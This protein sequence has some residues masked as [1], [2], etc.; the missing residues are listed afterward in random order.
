MTRFLGIGLAVLATG[1]LGACATVTRGANT[2]WEVKTTPPEAQVSTS[3]GFHCDF[4]PCSLRMPRKSRFTARV[5]KPGYKT[6]NIIV[7][8]KLAGAGG[9][10]FVGNALIGGVIG[11]GVDVASGAM[12]DLTPNPVVLK[13]E[14]DPDAPLASTGDLPPPSVAPPPATAPAAAGPTALS[15]PAAGAAPSH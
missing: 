14:I 3:N 5:S 2:A 4:T 7:T 12:L 1:S 11:A 6:V 10:G 15:A 9:A 13:L 8:N